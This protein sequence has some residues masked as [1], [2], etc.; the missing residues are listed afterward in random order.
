MWQH[1]QCGHQGLVYQY[2]DNSFCF[3]TAFQDFSTRYLVNTCATLALSN[4]SVS[5]M[6]VLDTMRLTISSSNDAGDV[7]LKKY[8]TMAKRTGGLSSDDPS[9]LVSGSGWGGSDRG[10][11]CST[12][13]AVRIGI[14]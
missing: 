7:T 6:D 1:L 12:C 10:G 14:F 9:V 8:W 11:L 4:C 3:M 2:N 5:G 13:T